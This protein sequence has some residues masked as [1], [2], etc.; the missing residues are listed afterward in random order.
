[1]FRALKPM[2]YEINGI[3]D[4]LNRKLDYGDKH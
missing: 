4:E 3:T 1:M 2:A